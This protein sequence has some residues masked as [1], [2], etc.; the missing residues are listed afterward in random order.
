MKKTSSSRS[1][2]AWNVLRLAL[3]WT[4]KGGSVFNLKLIRL[5]NYMKAIRIRNQKSTVGYHYGERQLSFDDTPVFHVKM[6]R[7][8]SLRFRLPHIPCINPHI[9]LRFDDE[10]LLSQYLDDDKLD[11]CT[12]R[13]SFLK[14]GDDEDAE[15]DEG[16]DRKAEEFIANFYQQIR[17]QRQI[18][19]LEYHQ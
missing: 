3:L 10:D 2:R 5:P 14:P 8:P 4:R 15:E 19:L 17:L 13:L 11:N 12:A 1:R 6:H 16:I 7:P 18:S 9:D